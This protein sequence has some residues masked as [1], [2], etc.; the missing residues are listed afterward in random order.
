V[1]TKCNLHFVILT[2][3]FI[4]IFNL[5]GGTLAT[6]AIYWPTVPGPDIGGNDC[7]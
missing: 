2:I 6:A 5:C 1:W 7:G 3:Y 4:F